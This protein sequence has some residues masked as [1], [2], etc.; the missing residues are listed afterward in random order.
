MTATPAIVV[1]PWQEADAP[2]LSRAVADSLEHLRPWMPWIEQEPM[3]DAARAAW[4]RD[5]GRKRAE[6][7]DRLL[8]IWLD[9][10]LVGACGL[11]PRI[12]PGGLELGYW[13]HVA[14]VRRG[15]ATQA[16]RVLCEMAFAEP[17]VTHVEIHHDPDNVASGRV[18]AALGFYPAGMAGEHSVWRLERAAWEAVGR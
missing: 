9:G 15:I 14:H 13:V 18:A 7:G 4:I 1:R 11:H 2:A 3:S 5:A 16:A 17:R 8:G 10:K 6:G 12:G